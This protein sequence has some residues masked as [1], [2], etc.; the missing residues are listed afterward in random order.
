MQI[1]PSTPI[2]PLFPLYQLSIKMGEEAKLQGN[3]AYKQGDYQSALSHYTLAISLQPNEANYY[4]NR[5]A[6]LIM[7]QRYTEGLE[8]CKAGLSLQPQHLRLLTRAGKCCLVTGKLDEAKGYYKA[9]VAAYPHNDGVKSEAKEAENAKEN[10]EMYEKC[11][12]NEQFPQAITFLDR[13]LEAVTESLEYKIQKAELLIESLQPAAA[14]T[15]VSSLPKDLLRVRLMRG[16]ALY[17]LSPTLSNEARA[18]LQEI[19]LS[20]PGNPCAEHTLALMRSMEELKTQGNSLFSAGRHKEAVSAYTQALQLDPKHRLF[21]STMLANRAAANMA[22]RNYLKALEDCNRSLSLNPDYTKAYL[23]RGNVHMQLEDY[24]EAVHDFNKVRELDENTP[25]ISGLISDAQT[26]A[27]QKGKKD[28]YQIL[29]VQRDANEADLKRAYRKLALKWHPDKNSDTPERRTQSE[30]KFKDVNEA[31]AVLSDREKRRSYDMDIDVDSPDMGM[32][33]FAGFDPFSKF[34]QVFGRDG[35][36][37]NIPTEATLTDLGKC[38]G[39]QTFFPGGV[40][41]KFKRS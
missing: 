21:N 10:E 28:Y 24:E 36:F 32:G 18:I 17:Y 30:K 38:G 29:E 8:D 40:K 39:E 26:K 31:Y 12:R 25:N 22:Q 23:R 4:A 13:L 6:A 11:R 3:E 37:G 19:S 1:S 2:F 27:K 14:L 35:V 5:S 33:G 9:A 20:D 15:W 7:L 34:Q 16:L 41:I